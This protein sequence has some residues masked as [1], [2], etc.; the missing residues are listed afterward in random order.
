LTLKLNDRV[1]EKKGTKRDRQRKEEREIRGERNTDRN[2]GIKR[3]SR[4]DKIRERKEREEEI[5]KGKK[6]EMRRGKKGRERERLT[7]FLTT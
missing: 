1:K 5:K 3:E 7:S 2:I 4:T 6:K